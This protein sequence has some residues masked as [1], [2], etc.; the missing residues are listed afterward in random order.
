MLFWVSLSFEI[1]TNFIE[2]KKPDGRNWQIVDIRSKV[3]TSGM[4]SRFTPNT[5]LT[6]QTSLGSVS[7]A[8]TLI[9]VCE[10]VLN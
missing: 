6:R 4:L 1:Q 3:D 8:S 2:K 10:A 9:Q 5:A 7:T